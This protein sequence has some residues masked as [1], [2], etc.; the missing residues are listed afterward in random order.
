MVSFGTYRMT[1]LI[2]KETYRTFYDNDFL[3]ANV[4]PC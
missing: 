1:Q 4:N 3:S 2:V